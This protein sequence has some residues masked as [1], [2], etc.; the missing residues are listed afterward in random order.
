M[1]G[2]IAVIKEF[3]ELDAI[4]TYGSIPSLRK[5][6]YD[7]ETTRKNYQETGTGYLERHPKMMENARQVSEI[8]T[9][10]NLEVKSAIEDLRDKHIQLNAQ[11]KEFATAMQKVQEDSRKLSEIEE[12]LRI[13]TDN[14]PL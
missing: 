1:E 4:E 8:K 12:H 10:L 6:L 5:T 7:L 3:F 14:L 11:E 13:L 2:D 9:T